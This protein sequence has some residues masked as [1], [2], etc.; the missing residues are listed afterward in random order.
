[1]ELKL[2]SISNAGINAA[3]AKAER[4]RYLNEPEEAESI[5]RDILAIE[6]THQSAQR[7]LG[8][9]ITDQFTGGVK[10][11][12]VEAAALFSGLAD[13]YSRLYYTGILHERHAKAQLRL[14]RPAPAIA[15]E[16]QEALNYFERA[17]QIRPAGN[18]ESILRWNRCA[19]L[20]QTLPETS[21]S[22]EPIGFETGDI[23]PQNPSRASMAR[24]GRVR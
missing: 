5:C 11:R 9:A 8:L 21:G 23:A 13:Q 17:E 14:G 22:D 16:F 1:M 12:F 3:I 20:L 24:A 19:R 4:Y 15:A 6:A 7:I 18:D 10:D 2:K